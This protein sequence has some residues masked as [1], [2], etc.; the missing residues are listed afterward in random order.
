MEGGV[1]RGSLSLNPGVTAP[2]WSS[3]SAMQETE[4]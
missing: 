2:D 3:D 1:L 4:T